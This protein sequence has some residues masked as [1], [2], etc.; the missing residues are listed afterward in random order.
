MNKRKKKSK[1][2]V[3]DFIAKEATR[4]LSS[5]ESSQV[6]QEESMESLEVGHDVMSGREDT[7]SGKIDSDASKYEDTFT[8]TVQK[9]ESEHN[10][11]AEINNNVEKIISS[12]SEQRNLKIQEGPV[13]G[14]GVPPLCDADFR[15]LKGDAN[16]RAIFWTWLYLKNSTFEQFNLPYDMTSSRW[17]V[18]SNS[19]YSLIP[20]P[21]D[22]GSTAERSRVIIEFF[23]WL[24]KNYSPEISKSVFENIRSI[25]ANFIFPVR[26]F[27]WL[28]KN[29]SVA[30]EWAMDYL[31]KK[32]EIGNNILTWFKPVG[33]HEAYISIMGTIDYW[34]I[35]GNS[36]D[37]LDKKRVLDD[38]YRAFKQRTRREKSNK[39]ILNAE[40]SPTARRQLK[41]LVESH[42]VKINKFIESLIDMEYQRYRGNIKEV[43]VM[44]SINKK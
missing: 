24:S 31:L 21:L 30:I 14:A 19:I 17:G 41:I 9:K 40:I 11:F 13:L 29:D 37:C 3:S 42:G 25:W 4:V 16:E 39:F 28:K 7:A 12:Y 23:D 1:V 38:M 18:A 6:D 10:T 8:S 43:Q 36:I 27:R 2:K 22:T 35:R 34:F 32:K 5:D 33:I 26:Q 20:L 15:W 44:P